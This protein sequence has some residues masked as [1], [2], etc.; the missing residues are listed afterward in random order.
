M[1]DLLQGLTVAGDYPPIALVLAHGVYVFDDTVDC[2]SPTLE[3]RLGGTCSAA[4]VVGSDI[5]CILG[6][7]LQGE[8]DRDELDFALNTIRNAIN[9]R[10]A[11]QTLEND[12]EQAA[13]IQRSL[14]PLEFPHFPG[15]EL[16]ARSVEAASVGGDFYDFELVDADI[17]A[18]GVGDASGHGLGA[19]LLAR[20]VVTGLRMGAEKDLRIT[21][22]VERLNRVISRNVLFTRFVSLFY[23]ELESNGNLFYVNAGHPPPWLFGHLGMRRLEIG[24]SILGPRPDASFKCGFAQERTNPAGRMFTDDGVDAVIRRCH[25]RSAGEI[26]AELFQEAQEFGQRQTWVDDTTVV[27]ITREAKGGPR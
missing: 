9:H 1:E 5:R 12:L 3:G 16:A 2:Q 7:G 22:V 24:G 11:V 25:R 19:A 13:D 4:L 21:A 14:L 26:V 20:D 17:L 8:W 15:Y 23:A 18:V 6:F 27:V 10:L